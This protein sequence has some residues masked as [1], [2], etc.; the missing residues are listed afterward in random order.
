M[1]LKITTLT[2]L[3]IALAG[4]Y[5]DNEE[6]LFVPVAVGGN[7]C[8][9]VAVT[10]TTSIAPIM[11]NYCTRCHRTG[12]TDGGVNIAGYAQLSV[13]VNSGQLLGAI[14]H[15]RGFSPMPSSGTRI[16][17]CDLQKIT[18]W[19]AAGAPNN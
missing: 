3:I 10:Y 2:L 15:D 12:R 17:A 11:T 18:T 13:Y 9:S 8:D 4:C 14:R 16:P 1:H 19:I 5:Y 7:T 6:D